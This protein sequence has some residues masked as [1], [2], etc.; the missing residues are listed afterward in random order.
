MAT[1]LVLAT[2]FM[3]PAAAAQAASGGDTRPAGAPSSSSAPPSPGDTGHEEKT[4]NDSREGDYAAY[5]LDPTSPLVLVNEHHP[6]HPRDYVPQ[7]LVA[8]NGSGARMVPEAAA[9]LERLLAAAR[10][11]GHA[12]IVESAYRSYDYQVGLFRRYTN[13]YGE[14]YA[15]RISARPG[16]SEHQLGLSADI[17]VASGQCSLKACL[18]DLPAGKWTAAHAAEYGFIIR[19]PQGRQ[20]IT[21]YNFEPWHLRY[22][23]VDAAQEMREQEV[24]TFEQYS[25]E[26][27]A[28]RAARQ[29][30]A[31]REAAAAQA[32][33]DAAAERRQRIAEETGW[34]PD[35]A[36]TAYG[37]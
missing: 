17:G 19:Y 33:R 2:A 37:Q 9:A 15:S 10:D 26:L 20:E 21:G 29:A 12:L 32:S 34:M 35:W 5:T 22:L 11:D 25:D 28:I 6:L 27:A 30:E 24:D 8:V 23:G 1:T 31:R 7:D 18:A 3:L 4:T 13:M 36:R 16:T 14:A